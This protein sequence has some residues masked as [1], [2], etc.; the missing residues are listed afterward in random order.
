MAV[1]INWA[2]VRR[3]VLND[4][5]MGY[6]PDFKSLKF[7]RSRL[8]DAK[9][10]GFGIYNRGLVSTTWYLLVESGYFPEDEQPGFITLSISAIP[11]MGR[12][13]LIL[14][15]NNFDGDSGA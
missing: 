7:L 12:P 15:P 5:L 10:H 8:H 3:V 4:R 13:K 1:S 11:I 6:R 14:A 2:R 9:V